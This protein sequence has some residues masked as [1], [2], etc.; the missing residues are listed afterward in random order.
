MTPEDKKHLKLL[1]EK[2]KNSNLNATEIA[3]YNRI[4]RVTSMPD[5]TQVQ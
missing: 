1:E 2:L 4:L 5:L 3:Y